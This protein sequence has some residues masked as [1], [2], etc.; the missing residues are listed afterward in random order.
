MKLGILSL[1][2]AAGIALSAQTASAQWIPANNYSYGYSP[3][4]SGGHL[5][6]HNGHYHY[7]NG[8]YRS[9][10][11]VPAVGLD[12]SVGMVPVIRA[13]RVPG[14]YPL[15]SAGTWSSYYYG[16]PARGHAYGSFRWRW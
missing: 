1:V 6:Y 8:Y 4:Y 10:A 9:G 14:Y 12:G 7:H 3:F 16:M 5:D 2:A 15:P 13:D 11:L